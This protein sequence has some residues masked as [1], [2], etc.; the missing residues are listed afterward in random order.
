M[1]MRF[2][3]LSMLVAA[4]TL[5]WGQEWRAEELSPGKRAAIEAQVQHP[6]AAYE[7]VPLPQVLVRLRSEF[8]TDAVGRWYGLVP[9]RALISDPR[10]VVY[11]VP[12]AVDAERASLA[13]RN[14]PRVITAH[15]EYRRGKVRRAFTP[16]DPYF[17]KNTPTSGFPG[18]WHLVNQ[19]VAG[20][21][22]NVWPAW[23][24]SVT[25]QGVII[26]IADDG[27]E[28][29]HPDL[30]PNYSA[31]HSWDF[32]RNIQDPNPVYSY[33]EHGTA[34][35]GLA[36]ARGG[37]GIGVTGAAPMATWAGLRL[38]FDLSPNS[39][40]VDVILFKSSGADTSIKIKNHSYGPFNPFIS[41]FEPESTALTTS[42]SAGTIHVFASGNDRSFRNE[43]ANKSIPQNNPF[44]LN[45]GSMGSNGSFANYSNFGANLA[46]VAP[47]S[48]SAGFGV[49]TTDRVGALGYG[50]FPDPDYTAA[51]GGTSAAAPIAAGV[52]ALVKQVQPNL[53]SRFLKHLLART[54]RKIDPS[55][56]TPASDGG[57]K[58]NAAGFS[59][60]Q[61]YG[62]GLLDADALTRE[63]VEYSGVTTL[64]TFDT[65]TV[66]VNLPIPDNNPAGA[67]H[68]FSVS[69]S[70]PLEE[71]IVRLTA[72]HG[73]RGD[74]EAYIT[75]PS[76]T[77]G[78][79]FRR[80]LGDSGS[81]L[82]WT[83]V[84]HTFWGENPQGTWQIRVVDTDATVVGTWNTYRAEFRMG[85]LVP[86]ATV[87]GTVTLGDFPP[88]PTGVPVV[89]RLLNPSTSAVVANTT[90]NL[91]PGGAF[92][93]A[94]GQTGTFHV[95]V[96][97]PHWLRRRLPNVTIGSSGVSGL[98][99]SL[100]NGD[101]NGDNVV[102]VMDFLALRAA[103]G[104]NSSSGN[105]NPNADLDGSGAVNV[106]DFL[107]LRSR[108]GQSGD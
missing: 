68:T 14:D 98:S 3:L 75:S 44:A 71:V 56:A 67:V 79:L 69:A 20:R 82:A 24:S 85:T 73:Y 29:N 63:A 8:V 6:L 83:F 74:L 49:T 59:F 80:H 65:G 100:V 22:T 18:Q 33:D 94:A 25:G 54:S 37:N 42:G 52:F 46:A 5:N 27:V 90:L 10:W 47:S 13:L 4:T 64:Q 17:P 32:Y 41:V 91:G 96:K 23:Q 45:I 86:A 19:H 12:S 1:H 51:F 40:Y 81:D 48:S 92:T 105:W 2:A 34:V 16:N 101:V 88:G 36:A 66:T 53:N 95:D 11:A 31:A 102:N 99:F 76:G 77:V 30:A 78:R 60:N 72:T 15:Q 55:D 97:G 107:I 87:S 26:G 21:D 89:V 106:G 39:N 50:G 28:T 43:D 93:W 70:A 9:Q 84:S 58:T 35:A 104:S 108:L 7:P 103:F 62:W 38:D 61:N 57:W